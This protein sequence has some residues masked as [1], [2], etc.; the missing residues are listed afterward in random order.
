MN[1]QYKKAFTLIELLLA[2]VLMALLFGVLY[3]AVYGSVKSQ[4]SVVE[5]L[6]VLDSQQW[7]LKLFADDIH[8]MRQI[9]S[10]GGGLMCKTIDNAQQSGV[11]RI[12]IKSE[13][14]PE[15]VDWFY[16]PGDEADKGFLARRVEKQ[17]DD[18][19]VQQDEYESICTPLAGVKWGFYDGENW[20]EQWD[21]AHGLPKLVKMELV[22]DQ[23]QGG[24]NICVEPL[25]DAPL[26]KSDVPAEGV[27]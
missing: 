4:R 20:V 12:W 22:V 10:S 17:N 13:N 24:R 14:G 2:V 15:I 1:D 8:M 21:V 7:A 6:D 23:T 3:V 9:S 27:E 26:I 19:I 25:I 18:Q 11:C 5:R 16:V